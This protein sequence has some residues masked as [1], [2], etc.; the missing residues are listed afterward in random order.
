MPSRV[1]G[2]FRVRKCRY[3]HSIFPLD[4]DSEILSIRGVREGIPITV[5]INTDLT[6]LSMKNNSLPSL[7]VA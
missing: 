2:N 1:E 3:R 6:T 5:L 4:R 7:L